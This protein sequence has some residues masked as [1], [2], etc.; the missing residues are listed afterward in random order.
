MTTALTES[1][2]LHPTRLGRL[3]VRILGAGEPV[4]LWHSMFTDSH[5]WDRLLPLLAG[6]R[7]LFVVDGPSCGQSD[8]LRADS[9]IAGCADAAVDLLA[10]LAPLTG[11]GPVSWLG[12]AWGGHVG[13]ELA[14]RR[15]DLV[16]DLVAVSAPTYPPPPALLRQLRVMLPLYRLVGPRGPVRQAIV[17]ALLTDHTRSEDAA[18]VEL[19]VG[20]LAERPVR[21]TLRAIRTGIVHRV[22]L[23]QQARAVRCPALFVTTDDRGEWTPEQAREM[24]ADMV[25]AREV[26]VPGSR[27]VPAI[28]Q[29]A[30]LAEAL[31]AF[32]ADGR[33][34][35]R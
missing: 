28:E 13:L 23:T 10:E 35:R 2:Q 6:S 22:D 30:V 3:H 12:N 27:V 26:T 32:W 18:G 34:E 33:A 15:P 8:A 5:S 7:R 17:S 29:P 25:D 21:D 9:D 14:A 16:R 11:P 19:L 4:V 1:T 31:L 24:A 20:R